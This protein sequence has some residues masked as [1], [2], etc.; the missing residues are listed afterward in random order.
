MVVDGGRGEGE[1][2]KGISKRR[3]EH[4]FGRSVHS[5]VTEPSDY[6]RPEKMRRAYNSEGDNKR[7]IMSA[8][9]HLLKEDLE[10]VWSRASRALERGAG[11]GQEKCAR[12]NT[13]SEGRR[14]GP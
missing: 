12:E 4:V 5:Y 13:T 3:P 10:L 1:S 9:S 14:R 8:G 7:E 6:S 11:G 2:E